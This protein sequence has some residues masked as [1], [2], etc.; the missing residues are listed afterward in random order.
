MGNIKVYTIFAGV[1]GAGKSTLFATVDKTIDLGV[2]LNSDEE[3]RAAGKDWRDEKAQIEAG[4]KILR[5]QKEC[6]DKGLS[7]NQETTLSGNSIVNTIKKA[8]S[9]G[10][11]I[12][13]RYVGVESPEIAKS[14]VE[15]RIALGGH[16]VSGATIDRRYETSQENFLKV[17]PLCDTVNIYDNSGESM[18]LVAYLDNGKLVRTDYPCA[19]VEKLLER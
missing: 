16:G 1:N 7:F 3:V 12:H 18:R 14:R 8:K 4:K 11:Q 17:F 10:Y 19:W 15:K 6:L 5:L 9:L 2:R 13:L